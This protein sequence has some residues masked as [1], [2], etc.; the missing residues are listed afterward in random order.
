VGR[1]ERAVSDSIR[2]LAGKMFG[3]KRFWHK[4]IVR[5]GPNTLHPYRENP[6]IG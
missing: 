2:D 4:R 3:V 1:G 5:A 6:R